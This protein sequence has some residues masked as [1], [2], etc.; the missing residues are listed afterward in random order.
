MGT[1]RERER[2]RER[3]TEEEIIG[4]CDVSYSPPR[5]SLSLRGGGRGKGE[6]ERESKLAAPRGININ[7]RW[8]TI[9]GAAKT[10]I[11]RQFSTF[12]VE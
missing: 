9:P 5:L 1:N 7:V 11:T 4:N 6:I 12:L 2:E 3:P 8:E 10:V